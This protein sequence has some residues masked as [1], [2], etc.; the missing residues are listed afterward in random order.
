MKLLPR[1]STL[2]V[3]CGY[4]YSNENSPK[5]DSGIIAVQPSG[6]VSGSNTVHVEKTQSWPQ[7]PPTQSAPEIESQISSVHSTQSA[8]Q[9]NKSKHAAAR[10]ANTRQHK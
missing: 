6:Y 2:C 3:T 4:I 5:D 1:I 10:G 7:D 8:L 9:G